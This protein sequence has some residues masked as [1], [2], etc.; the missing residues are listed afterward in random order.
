MSTG[1]TVATAQEMRSL[2]EAL[3]SRTRSG[4]VIILIGELGGGKTT[5][6]QGIA[7][8]VGISDRITS[9]TFVV[10]RVHDNPG[11]GPSLV[12]VDA[13]RL[14]GR[15]ELDDLDLPLETSVT[16]VEWGKG[17]ADHL[18]EERLEISILAVDDTD[19][20]LVR[21]TGT[22]RWQVDVAELTGDLT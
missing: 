10:A 4:D 20:R 13:Y 3:G 15:D 2:G 8:G 22:E 12:H 5:L 7:Q 21:L 16:V 14:G 17:I 1:L 11:G 9:P 6:V 18:A 19:L